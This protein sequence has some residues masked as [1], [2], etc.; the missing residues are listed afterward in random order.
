[1]DLLISH[2]SEVSSEDLMERYVSAVDFQSN[3]FK[4]LIQ[5]IHFYRTALH[6]AAFYGFSDIAETLISSSTSTS[7]LIDEK[8]LD[9]K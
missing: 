1:M 6:Y 4:K 5:V 9:G 8:D 3:S 2:G 7:A